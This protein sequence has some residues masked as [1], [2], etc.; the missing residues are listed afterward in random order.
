MMLLSNCRG[1]G[2]LSIIGSLQRPRGSWRRH[3]G[4]S[5]GWGVL[6]ADVEYERVVEIAAAILGMVN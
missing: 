3:G 5:D 6:R 2:F 1:R 4:Q